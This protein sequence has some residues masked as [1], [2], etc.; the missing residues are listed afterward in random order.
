MQELDLF[1]NNFNGVNYTDIS[2]TLKNREYTNIELS[3][4]FKEKMYELLLSPRLLRIV[5][6]NEMQ[7]DLE[8]NTNVIT[9]RPKL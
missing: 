7:M 1:F 8:N 2:Q 6:Y 4:G 9:T 5:Q 3:S